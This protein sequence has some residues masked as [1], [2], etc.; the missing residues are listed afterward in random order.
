MITE[1]ILAC[2]CSRES[3]LLGI[4]PIK[5]PFGG[6]FEKCGFHRKP[7]DR[8]LP[9][10]LLC[11]SFTDGANS[12]PYRYCHD[13]GR[14]NWF[15]INMSPEQCCITDACSDLFSFGVVLHEMA[16]GQQAF[17]GRT[18]AVI[19]D[20]ILHKTPTSP[21]RL[22]PE[23]P[24]ELKSGEQLTVYDGEHQAAGRRRHGT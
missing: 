17:T 20:A 9:K 15:A 12:S 24:E 14:W 1:Q 6:N 18:S 3:E 5:V 21:V 2:F 19:F 7:P 13:N 11:F 4:I 8:H 22:N 16:T 10:A 23:I